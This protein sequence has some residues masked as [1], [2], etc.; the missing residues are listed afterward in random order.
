MGTRVT[1][2]GIG[3]ALE[4]TELDA[5][6]KSRGLSEADTSQLRAVFEER[7]EGLAATAALFAHVCRLAGTDPRTGPKEIR[8]TLDAYEAKRRDAVEDL[9]R[10]AHSQGL[11]DGH[12]LSGYRG[13]FDPAK[14]IED[15]QP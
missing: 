11:S 10:A 7:D 3:P 1:D 2:S 15:N 5:W 12:D 8:A 4:T 13:G 14:F 6:A 9:V